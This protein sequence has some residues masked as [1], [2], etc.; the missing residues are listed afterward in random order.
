MAGRRAACCICAAPRYASVMRARDC[1]NVE[2]FRRL[3]RRRLPRP[4]FDYIDG[5][6]DDEVTCRRNVASFDEC[7]LVPNVL[8]GV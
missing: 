7:D 2:D 1:H 6:A 8:A 5:G 3:A 4:V